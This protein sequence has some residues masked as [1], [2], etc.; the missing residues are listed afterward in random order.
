MYKDAGDGVYT[1]AALV[2][3][4]SPSFRK[5]DAG[6]AED[7]G[8]MERVL[9][10]AMTYGVPIANAVPK[11]VLPATGVTL[12]GKAL[13]DIASGLGQQTEGTLIV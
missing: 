6:V 12:A 8:R 4:A 9:G 7:A 1:A 13:V 11:Y 10:N 2:G 5:F 3:G